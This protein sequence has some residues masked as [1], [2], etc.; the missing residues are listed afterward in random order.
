MGRIRKLQKII[1]LKFYL[2]FRCFILPLLLIFTS[3]G[4]STYPRVRVDHST[5]ALLSPQATIPEDQLLDVRIQIFDPS[6]MKAS[7]QAELGLS[8]EINKMETY[9]IA[10]H[11]KNAVQRT[12]YW[13][14]VRVVPFESTSDELLV[15]GQII[16][17]NGEQL[18][19]KINAC[20]STGKQWFK[21]KIF[22]GAVNENMYK[23]STNNQTEVFQDVYNRIANELSA[24]RAN[25]Q[26]DEVQKIRN[27]AEM[28]FAEELAPT[29]FAGYLKKDDRSNEF[30]IDHLPAED[31][32]FL[33][34]VRRVRERDYALVDTLDAHCESLHRTMSGAYTSWRSSRLLEMN[35]IRKI[36]SRRNAKRIQG[37]IAIVGAIL[38]IILAAAAAAASANSANGGYDN[39]A[40][41]TA[42]AASA[43]AL[44]AVGTVL[45]QQASQIS[46]EAEIN[47]AALAELGMSFASDVEPTIV[48]VEGE[49]IKLTGS[50]K[51]KYEQWRN[52]I[53]RLY[54]LETTPDMKNIESLTISNG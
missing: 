51:A 35:M 36:E 1:T 37:V 6:E 13:G 12:G 20:D 27:I 41:T 34:K 22:K 44:A 11:L 30:E 54:E 29:V 52:V 47:K 53:G 18:I 10:T 45:L 28:R 33:S 21:N 50:A 48:N 9:Y 31:D 46:K 7:K 15:T 24:Y 14:A 38:M 17:S 19:L 8:E 3:F 16:E 39:T 49:T 25:M 32:E 43:G 42:G 5:V 26:P 40:T 4:C 23:N 2:G